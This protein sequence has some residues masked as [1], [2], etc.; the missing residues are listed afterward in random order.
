MIIYRPLVAVVLS[1]VFGILIEHFLAL[2]FT[3][4]AVLLGI[5]LFLNFLFVHRPK[6]S[7]ALLLISFFVVGMMCLKNHEISARDDIS[8]AAKYYRSFPIVVEGMIDSDIQT[9]KTKTTFEL[10]IKN[11]QTPWGW[12]KKTGRIL[13]NAFKGFNPS[14]GDV[15]ILKGKLYEPFDFNSKS[16]DKFHYK[17]YLHRR[18]INLLLSVK[19][20][21][22]PQTI[23]HANA[24]PVQD[25]AL[26]VKHRVKK[27]FYDNLSFNEAAIVAAIILGDRYD[28]PKHIN[29]IFIQTG[30][31]HILAIS[32]QNVGIVAFLIFILLKM[33]PITRRGHFILTILLL[34]FYCFMTGF[35][36]PVVRATIMAVVFLL[37]FLVE[38]ETDTV[39]S[40]AL[41]SFIILWLNPYSLFDV[42][43]QLSF[44]SVLMI[45]LCYRKVWALVS[46]A[47][48]F[49]RQPFR[50]I[51]EAAVVSVVA[52]SAVAGLIAYY[53]GMVTPITLIANLFIV[54]CMTAIEA[55]GLGL[56]LTGIFIPKLNFL[57]A[58]CLKASLSLMVFLA[59]IFSQIP[60]AYFNL[61][62]VS[63]WEIIGYYAVLAAGVYFFMRKSSPPTN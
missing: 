17:D 9:R 6:F 49:D 59:Y 3:P 24:N 32:G 27:V 48:I 23:A 8:F 26:K 45:V 47:E 21:S 30:T 16:D 11:I 46:K 51:L 18:G 62:S 33:F 25:A 29:N 36:A 57:F 15:V 35:Q 20:D 2:S 13:V 63:L 58:A 56:S 38:R 43:F 55:L 37:S 4:L 61:S 19:K 39:N 60:F 28:I 40:L 1:F 42:S 41:A 54:P 52:W 12:R 5:V 44:I 53:F 34:I 50:F 22:A 7:S 14:Y 10:E 31:A